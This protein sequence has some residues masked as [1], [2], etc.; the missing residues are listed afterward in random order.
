MG[1]VVKKFY[2]KDATVLVLLLICY[3]EFVPLDNKIYQ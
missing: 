3:S 1:E 2:E